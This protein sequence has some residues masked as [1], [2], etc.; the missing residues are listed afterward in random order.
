MQYQQKEIVAVVA[1]VEVL[2]KGHITQTE[3]VGIRWR[4]FPLK[5]NLPSLEGGKKTSLSE[6]AIYFESL[7]IPA[8]DKVTESDVKEIYRKLSM[9]H[10]PDK[11]GI[12]EKFIEITECKNKCLEY[13]KLTKKF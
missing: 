13:F 4:S 6:Y 12:R 2:T 10:H 8:N 3:V 1:V 11:G 9:K 7:G 5:E